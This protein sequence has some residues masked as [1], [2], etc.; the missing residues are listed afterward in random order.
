[1]VSTTKVMNTKFVKL[2]KSTFGA[3]VNFAFD[4][5]GPLKF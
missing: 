2:I 5:V 3:L 1:M 4:K